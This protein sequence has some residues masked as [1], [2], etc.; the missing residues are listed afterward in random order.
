MHKQQDFFGCLAEILGC[1]GLREAANLEIWPL[2]PRRGRKGQSSKVGSLE[3]ALGQPKIEARPPKRS[4]C[5]CIQY[6][7]RFCCIF[8]QRFMPSHHQS[9]SSS[10]GRASGSHAAAPCLIPGIVYL[11][12]VFY[13]VVHPLRALSFGP[14]CWLSGNGSIAEKS[15]ISSLSHSNKFSN[16]F[17][18]IRSSL[19]STRLYLLWILL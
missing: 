5:I 3:K 4:R 1:L 6:N 17:G 7:R 11:A 14:L 18:C 8:G 9:L 19:W 2:R 10:V 12:L 16:L 13:N 15:S